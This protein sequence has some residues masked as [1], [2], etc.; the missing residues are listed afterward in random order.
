MIANPIV[1]ICTHLR[2]EI[3]C[4]N[5]ESLLRQSVV[6]KIILCVSSQQEF[7]YFKTKY[8][9][10]VVVRHPNTPL[11]SKWHHGVQMSRTLNANPLI[12]L[13]SDDIL[14]ENYIENC[15]KLTLVGNHFIGLQRFYIHQK[16]NAYL[17]DYLA[18]MPI[19]SGRCYSAEMLKKLDYNIFDTQRNKHLD[20]LGFDKTRASELKVKWV[21]DVIGE[22]LIVH[23]IKGDWP[24]M[25]PVNLKHQNIKLISTHDS[26]GILSIV[27]G[28]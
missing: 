28:G 3:T 14:G 26:K 1:L 8:H 18:N 16:G 19:G 9:T 2:L 15:T 27:F 10:V 7:H 23:A 22:N 6:P 17:V 20:D 25:N 12:I 21:R 11:G 4:Y 5:I 13:G 24:M